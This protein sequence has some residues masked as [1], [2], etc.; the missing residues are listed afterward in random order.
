MEPRED[1]DQTF[2][3][4]ET[5][6]LGLV[7]FLLTWTFPLAGFLMIIEASTWPFFALVGGGTYRYLA[8][9]IILRLLSAVVMIVLAI[10][11]LHVAQ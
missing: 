1:L 7:D 10:R 4:I 3:I 6:S 8:A 9:A 2:Y 11:A 5:E